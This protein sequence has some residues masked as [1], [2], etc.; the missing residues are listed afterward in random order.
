MKYTDTV[1]RLNA[2]GPD[3]W[4][5]YRRAKQMIVDGHDVIEMAI[6]QPDVETPAA[7]VDATIDALRRGR[8]DYS[9]SLGEPN[10]RAALAQRYSESVG[11]PIE[12]EQIACLPGT[13]TALYT[14]MRAIAGPGDHVVVADPM[15]ATYGPVMAAC[16]AMPIAVPL[17]AERGFR[18]DPAEVAAAITPTTT[19]IL[20]N[21]PH[22][23]TGTVLTAD[24][25]RQVG[26]VAIDHD[27][28]LVT[29]EVYEELVFDG[30]PFFSP[31]AQPDLADRTI[32]LN[33]ISK[34]HA[35]PGF[36]SGWC[37]G[38]LGFCER[39]RP[40]AEAVLFGSQPFIADATAL[41]VAAPSLA[42]AS[43]ATRF[44]AR[45]DRL[46]ARLHAETSLRV[47]RPAAG[48]FALVD[49]S[50]TGLSGEDYA[51]DL[52]DTVGVAVLPGSSFGASLEKWVRVSLTRS[53]D[54]FDEGC[55][56][57]VEH[58]RRHSAGCGS[59]G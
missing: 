46:V 3:S 56:R 30:A 57:V 34:S 26:Q 9:A 38:P 10:L 50:S 40:L 41:A 55:R 53:D 59:D 35:A 42:A 11:R 47:H 31:L 51:A 1:A 28:W 14:V 37:V 27:V 17:R 36:R 15:Y 23:P 24:D 13:Q 2:V 32:V 44:A 52:L 6:G 48:M 18:I 7:I 25:I 54:A 33:S 29:D 8:T 4:A 5:L 45:A 21:T 58:A 20:L 12:V 19:A 43:M 39:M 16:G 22:N 49:V